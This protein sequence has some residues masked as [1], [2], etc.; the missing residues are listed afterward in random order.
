[1]FF[2]LLRT[3][4]QPIIY[5]RPD[6][7]SFASFVSTTHTKH[8]TYSVFLRPREHVKRDKHTIYYTHDTRVIRADDFTRLADDRAHALTRRASHLARR[9]DD[10][11]RACAPRHATRLC[12]PPGTPNLRDCPGTG[13]LLLLLKYFLRKSLTIFMLPS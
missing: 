6:L 1:M 10:D 13:E 11:D 12:R 5:I 4:H 9:D 3:D 8:T 7:P 2:S